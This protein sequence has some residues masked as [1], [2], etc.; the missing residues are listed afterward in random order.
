M[1]SITHYLKS[2]NALL[3]LL[4]SLGLLITA[5]Q[6]ISAGPSPAAISI[7]H[8]ELMLKDDHYHLIARVDY[9]LNETVME[10][11]HNG[12]SITIESQSRLQR[13]RKWVWNSTINHTEQR[14]KL[15][16]FALSQLYLVTDLSNNSKRSFLTLTAALYHLGQLDIK[17]AP[18]HAVLRGQP[19]RY[20]MRIFLNLDSLPAPLRPLAYLS[21]QWSLTSKWQHWHITP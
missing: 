3:L 10:A 6:K 12:V 19:H 16:Y 18:K 4:L 17:L 11:L 7:H 15:R 20:S 13:L 2:R 8:S 14:Y 5:S 21:T 1:V 9:Q